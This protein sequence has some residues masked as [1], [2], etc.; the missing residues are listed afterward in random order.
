[1]T[2]SNEISVREAAG[3]TDIAEQ[4][5]QQEAYNRLYAQS[6]PLAREQDD[7]TLE[8]Y[9]GAIKQTFDDA[10]AKYNYSVT[11]K[12][13]DAVE[14]GV[15]L[16]EA[17]VDYTASLDVQYDVVEDAEQERLLPEVTLD[18]DE[19]DALAFPI[20]TSRQVE[21][22]QD[23]VDF[24]LKQL[25]RSILEVEAQLA[26]SDGDLEMQSA[27][28]R[29]RE[30]YRWSKEYAVDT[31]PQQAGLTPEEKEAAERAASGEA[32]EVEAEEPNEEMA[33]KLEAQIAEQ[34]AKE[35]EAREAAVKAAEEEAAAAKA[36]QER[37]EAEKEEAAAAAEKANQES[38]AADAL[39][40]LLAAQEE[41][42]AAEEPAP[43]RRRLQEEGER[44]DQLTKDFCSNE[45]INGTFNQDCMDFARAKK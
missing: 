41:S 18:E 6:L 32:E 38:A 26:A 7:S 25:F 23:D 37:L 39:M 17:L 16:A 9:F 19:Q 42:Q 2:N 5:R 20:D 40:A 21:G 15:A 8:L 31:G 29:A 33:A 28:A 12:K 34:R 14:R 13:A 43:S 36:E 10:E 11:E 24:R 44:P 1:M 35:Q 4:A 3:I 45:F 27:L 30:E 22:G